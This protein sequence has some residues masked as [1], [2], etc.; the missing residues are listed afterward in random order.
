MDRLLALKPFDIYPDDGQSSEVVMITN[1][2]N[3]ETSEKYLQEHMRR[4]KAPDLKVAASLFVKRYAYLVV[5]SALYS[6][7]EFNSVL[8]IPVSACGMDLEQKLC[9]QPNA[10]EW[11][12][13]KGYER[14]Q[15]RES[16][17]RDLFTSQITPMVLILNRVTGISLS[18]LWENVAIRINSIYRKMS[19]NVQD[20]VKLERINS[21]FY[22]LQH[23]NGDLFQLK[24]NPLT[25][26][27]KIGVELKENPFR[28][29]CC[30]YYKVEEDAEGS[31]Y[32]DNCPYRRVFRN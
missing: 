23:A 26:Y 25:S 3:E 20:E 1:L 7:V 8:Y 4:I 14:D 17:L 30:L 10:C 16:V 2:M 24:N 27:L 31:G 6:M 29:T 15:W 22:Y 5:A 9:I 21:D 18:I 28:K 12:D 13:A 11:H 32:C 19:T